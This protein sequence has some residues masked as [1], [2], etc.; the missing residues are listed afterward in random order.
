[1]HVMSLYPWSFLGWSSTVLDVAPLLVIGFQ[2]WGISGVV[3]K[4]SALHQWTCSRF[5]KL[6]VLREQVGQPIVPAGRNLLSLH[7]VIQH[8]ICIPEEF[9]ELSWLYL[10]LLVC[11]PT[12]ILPWWCTLQMSTFDSSFHLARPRHPGQLWPPRAVAPALQGAWPAHAAW[13]WP[14]RRSSG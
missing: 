8:T 6:R 12:S 2:K 3:G 11:T 13:R 9:L 5:E 14:W 10:T 7:N 4:R 1:M